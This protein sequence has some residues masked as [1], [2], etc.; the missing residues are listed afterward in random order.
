FFNLSRDNQYSFLE[1]ARKHNLK[2]HMETHNPNRKR[3]YVCPEGDCGHPFT[4]KHDLKRHVES[5][6]G[7]REK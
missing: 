5:M 3:P 2:T 1:S 7:D 4:R 6:H